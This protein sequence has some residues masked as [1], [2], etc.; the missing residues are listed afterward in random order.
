[1][2]ADPD[3]GN[4]HVVGVF[5]AIR[6]RSRPAFPHRHA[7]FCAF[8][9]LTDA[10]GEVPAHVVVTEATTQI[11][12]ARSATH[13][14]AFPHRRFLLQTLFRLRHCTF[15]RAGVYWVQLYCHRRFLADQ[16]LLLRETGE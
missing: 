13:R 6:P 12:I 14:L 1:V 3:R 4:V 9:Q 8:V 5:N 15:P 2:L 7:Q 16:V 11:P 10:V